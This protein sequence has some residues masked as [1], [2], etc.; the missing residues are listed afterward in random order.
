MHSRSFIH[1]ANVHHR[2]VGQ[3]KQIFYIGLFHP[4]QLQTTG[5]FPLLQNFFVPQQNVIGYPGTFITTGYRMV[6]YLVNAVFYGF[7]IF[8]LKFGIDDLFVPDRVYAT[9]HMRNIVVVK[10]AQN[11][12]NGI[13]LT[14]IGQKFIA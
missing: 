4:V 9:I 13:R 12:Q 1:I 6:A 8:D 5:R 2:L 10:T 7:Q 14:N 11:M 3:Q